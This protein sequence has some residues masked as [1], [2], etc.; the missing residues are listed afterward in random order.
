[1][2]AADLLPCVPPALLRAS[3]AQH[4]HPGS[5]AR[6]LCA[7]HCWH[8]SPLPCPLLATLPS[9]G[10]RHVWHPEITIVIKE[11][12]FTQ[13]VR[14]VGRS[15]QDCKTEASCRCLCRVRITAVQ[16]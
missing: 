4:T 15:V 7:A 12:Y 16:A 3:R 5:H 1:M 11:I 13:A 14:L 10:P 9:S 6:I 8:E 2:G